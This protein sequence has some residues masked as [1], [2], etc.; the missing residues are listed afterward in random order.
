MELCI[1]LSDC[2]S[3]C[4]LLPSINWS[5]YIL[6]LVRKV[7]V[8]HI[9]LMLLKIKRGFSET[10]QVILFKMTCTSCTD[11]VRVKVPHFKKSHFF[12]KIKYY[13]ETLVVYFLSLFEDVTDCRDL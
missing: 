12:Y 11:K 13:T 7:K 3:R 5:A 10:L 1:D 2:V 8:G 9:K 6:T 4:T